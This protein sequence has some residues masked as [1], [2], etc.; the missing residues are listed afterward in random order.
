MLDLT[1]F[2]S[3][4][5]TFGFTALLPYCLTALL[6]YCFTALLLYHFGLQFGLWFVDPSLQF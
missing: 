5:F 3:F 2:F 6:L 4:C 1:P